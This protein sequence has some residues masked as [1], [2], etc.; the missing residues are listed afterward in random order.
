MDRIVYLHEPIREKK[1]F[2]KFVI[3]LFL[4]LIPV[5]IF[6][7]VALLGDCTNFE[8]FGK[9]GSGVAT[10]ATSNSFSARISSGALPVGEYT[11]TSYSGRL[12]VLELYTLSAINISS[13]SDLREIVRGK[14]GVGTDEDE[15]DLIPDDVNFT[16]LVFVNDTFKGIPEINVSFFFNGSVIGSK[17]SNASGG[18]TLLYD[19]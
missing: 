18:A 13:H 12:G 19:K 17:N 3:L 2:G 9:K 14:A 8:N 10:N 7:V 4:L 16:A 1:R 11:T 15:L 6:G 5:L